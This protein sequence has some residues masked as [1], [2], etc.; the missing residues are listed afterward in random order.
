LLTL[1]KQLPPG[2]SNQRS[3]RTGHLHQEL[4]Q[5]IGGTSGAGQP[6][7]L[8]HRLAVYPGL[9]DRADQRHRDPTSIITTFTIMRI[10]DFTLN[11]MTLLGLTPGRWNRNR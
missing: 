8:N 11:S 5:G 6:A 10:M 1:N 2:V 4:R 3:Q 7:R 9:A